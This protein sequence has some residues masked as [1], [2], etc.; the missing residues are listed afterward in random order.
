MFQAR[1]YV[2]LPP[3][4]SPIRYTC[5]KPFTNSGH[6]FPWSGNVI[7][8]P[9]CMSSRVVH[10]PCDGLC[11]RSLIIFSDI[12][13]TFIASSERGA[14][15]ND[16]PLHVLRYAVTSTPFFLSLTS[17]LFLSRPCLLKPSLTDTLDTPHNQHTCHHRHRTL[18]WVP[19]NLADF[20]PT[21]IESF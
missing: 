2:Q 18:S 12:R 17:S 21:D 8:S 15:L 9:L 16:R 6:R 4:R 11:H 1:D 5:E 20:Q 14:L 3:A 13:L 7:T 19:P 10:E